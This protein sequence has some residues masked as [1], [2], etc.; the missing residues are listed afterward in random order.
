MYLTV[1]LPVVPITTNLSIPPTTPG[2]WKYSPSRTILYE[3]EKLY[4]INY[5]NIQ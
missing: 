5:L 4:L 2:I 1:D 3:T